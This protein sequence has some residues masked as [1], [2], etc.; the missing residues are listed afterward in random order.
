MT[1]APPAVDR[2]TLD[3]WRRAIVAAFGAGGI[4]VTA[5]GPRLPTLK[6]DFGF[7][8][9]TIGLLLAGATV[10]A[11]AGLV[12]STPVLHLMGSRRGVAAS[13]F[14]VG[15]AMTTMGVAA[16]VRSVPLLATAFLMVGFGIGVLDV[17]INVEGSANE[18]ADGRTLMPRM[19]AAWSI[20]AVIGAGIGTACAALGIA[21]SLQF[22]GEAVLIGGVGF[23]IAPAIPLGRRD[24]GDDKAP[25]ET[26][27]ERIR[28]WFAC[29]ADRRLLL[30]GLV[31]LGVEVGEGSAN[32]WLT[33]A[34]HNNHGLTAAIA[35]GF[36]TVFAGAEAL[37]RIFG[38]PIVDSNRPRRHCAVHHGNRHRRD[39]ALH[40]R[41]ELVARPRRRRVLGDRGVDGLPPRDVR[42]CGE[43]GERGGPRERGGCD[44]LLREHRRTTS[45]RH[46]G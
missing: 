19:H 3:R 20:G 22:I 8:T 25:C 14:L 37:A 10:G 46:A 41:F 39:G 15:V 27:A 43:R 23:A 21:P 40:P 5:W 28:K 26:R 33:L 18:R 42:R 11:I 38:G 30:I 31:M 45:N 1:E 44:R 13:L 2:R 35:A 36:F 32:T 17:L 7:G 16:S 12:V 4:T 24:T 9:A 6:A 34:V 29:W